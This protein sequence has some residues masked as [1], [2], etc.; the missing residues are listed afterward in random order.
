MNKLGVTLAQHRN[1]QRKTVVCF[2]CNQVGHIA[3]YCPLNNRS[4]SKGEHSN[5]VG[6]TGDVALISTILLMNGLSN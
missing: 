5:M 3:K 6:G 4:E 2:K 1:D